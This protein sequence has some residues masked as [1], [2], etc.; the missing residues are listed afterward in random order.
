MLKE[1]L[2]EFEES[3]N[4]AGHQAGKA[5]FLALMGAFLD[6]YDLLIMGVIL[7]SLIP[8]WHLSSASV[9]ALVASAFLGMVIGAA[10][11]GTIADRIGRRAVFTIDMFLFIGGAIACGLA[12]NA[13]ELMIF[14]FFVGMAIGID[15]PTSTAII[16]EYSTSR[17]RG[18][19]TTLMQV[20][21]PL[22]SVVASGVALMLYFYGG[23]NAW[24]WMFISGLVPAILVLLLRKDLTETPY[25]LKA[26]EARK[27]ATDV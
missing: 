17:T 21:W 10:V 4:L 8:Q 27:A 9:G 23:P 1:K 5:I 20:F 19:N 18:R 13:L 15:A 24:R 2:A 7:L 14:R 6:G 12:R 3:G 11:F 16:A 26:N 25:W 22:G